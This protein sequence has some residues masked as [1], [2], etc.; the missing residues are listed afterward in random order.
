[1]ITSACLKK[2]L[3]KAWTNDYFYVACLF[4]NTNGDQIKSKIYARDFPL[5][6]L[7]DLIDCKLDCIEGI[8]KIGGQPTLNI[9]PLNNQSRQTTATIFKTIIERRQ[10]ILEI[11]PWKG[12]WI[13]EN[14]EEQVKINTDKALLEKIFEIDQE[15]EAS[16]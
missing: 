6:I 11:I 8:A 4:E 3:Y 12:E 9:L 5:P 2:L 16:K 1:M 10:E 7:N 14:T 15:G 13:K